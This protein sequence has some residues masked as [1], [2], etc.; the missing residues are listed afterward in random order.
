M[1]QDDWLTGF[2]RNGPIVAVEGDTLT[3]TGDA[4]TITLVDDGV[5]DPEQ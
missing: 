2:L 3:L 5:A 1:A 4:A